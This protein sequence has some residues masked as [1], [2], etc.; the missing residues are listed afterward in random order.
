MYVYQCEKHRV[1]SIIR[2]STADWVTTSVP[3]QQLCSQLYSELSGHKNVLS[4]SC[5]LFR[6]TTIS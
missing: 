3:M 6:Q 1:L 2:L 4:A 5:S